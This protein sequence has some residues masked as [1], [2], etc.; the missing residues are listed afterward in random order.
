M[1]ARGRRCFLMRNY[2][3]SE[4]RAG[5]AKTLPVRWIGDAPLNIT[6]FDVIFRHDVDHAS[7]NKR[8]ACLFLFYFSFERYDRYKIR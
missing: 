6:Y 8:K 2:N 5:P 3:Y 1:L 7:T 4:L